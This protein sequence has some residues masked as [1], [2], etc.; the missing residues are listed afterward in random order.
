MTLSHEESPISEVSYRI[1]VIC[2]SHLPQDVSCS[3][4]GAVIVYRL[5]GMDTAKVELAANGRHI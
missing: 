3:M 5:I 1:D 2:A 4:G